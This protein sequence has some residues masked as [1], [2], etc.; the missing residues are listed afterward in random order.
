[1]ISTF[2]VGFLTFYAGQLGWIDI[3][4]SSPLEALLF[5]ALISAVDPVATL[6]ILGNP[7]LNVDTL[8]YSLVFGESVL[9]D[10]VAIVLFNTFLQF[11]ASQEEFTTYAVFGL[12]QD[13]FIISLGSIVCGVVTGYVMYYM[14]RGNL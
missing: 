12:L 14:P 11:Q 13:F 2:V 5:G 1:M 9:N 10:A 4:T 3:D 8:L 7:E 6:S